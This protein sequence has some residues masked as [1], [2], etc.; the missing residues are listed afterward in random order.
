MRLSRGETRRDVT[1][2]GRE[3]VQNFHS[4]SALA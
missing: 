1:E 4:S 2:L 3:D